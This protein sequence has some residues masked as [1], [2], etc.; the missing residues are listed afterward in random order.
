MINPKRKLTRAVAFAILF[1]FT[2]LTGAQ[3]L[4]AI[5][6]N[7]QLPVLD[8]S[9]DPIG[10]VT[11]P[12]LNAI[13]DNIMNI[14][15]TDE[16]SIIKWK[17]FSIG[18]DAIVNFTRENGGTFN[19]LNFVNSGAV[20]EIY[21]QLTALG[22][23]IFIANPAGVTIGNSA[24]I[25]VGS[26]YVTNKD[27]GN[28]VDSLKGLKDAK[29]IRET[30][31]GLSAGTNAQLMSLG[32]I[33]NATNVTFD[34]A[35]IV[36]DTDR[37]YTANGDTGELKQVNGDWFAG[38]QAGG[39]LLKTTG[40][41]IIT[42]D[43]DNVILGY[44]KDNSRGVDF[45]NF[46]I[47]VVAN[48]GNVTDGELNYG[49]TWIHDLAE[50]H[51]MND[52]PSG[53]YA[54]RNSID[55]Y[56]TASID[57]GKGF[58]PIG[59]SSQAFTGRFDGLG[60]S[61]FGLNVKEDT[62]AAGL[63]GVT[64][65]AHLK[66]FT[67]NG[68]SISGGEYV[69]AAVGSASGG[70]IENITNTA[71]VSGK[72]AEYNENGYISDGGVGGI[73]GY[74]GGTTMSGLINIGT[75][76]GTDDSINV[77]GIVGNM[78][79]STLTGETYNLGSVTGGWNIGGIA[80]QMTNSA[81]IG[82]VG[83]DA[84]QIYNQ[85]NVEGKYNVGGIAGTLSGGTI[86]NAANYGNVTAEGHTKDTYEYHTAAAQDNLD[87]ATL[88]GNLA[89]IA[90]K[91]A[92]A[93][94]IA[95]KTENSAKISNVVNEGDV[96]TKTEGDDSHYIAGN[97]GGIVGRAEDT[98]I[99]NAENKENT[100]AGAHNVGGVAGFLG[101]NS[102]VDVGVN[103]GGD[104]TATGARRGNSYVKERIR[105]YSP[106][107]N[108]AFNVGN[109]GGI[110]GYLF[111]DKAKVKNSGN[112]GT[113][114]SANIE[115]V[116]IVPET[117]KAA[118]V[119]GVV[120]KI[121]M[122]TSTT[123]ETVKD[124][125]KDNYKNGVPT[126][127]NSYSTGN[128]RGYTGVGG[129][130]GMMYNGSVAGSYNLGT[131]QSSR[132][133]S[134]GREPLNMGGVVGDTT[135]DT[136]ANAVIYDVYN[137]G[138]IGDDDYEYYGR[139][140]GGVVGRLSGELEKAYNTGD[141][142]NGY[143]TVGGI[144][145]WWAAGD[146][147]N[148]FN[149]GNITVVNNDDENGVSQVGGIAGAHSGAGST[150]SYAYNLGTIRSFTP[151]GF[152]TTGDKGRLSNAVG[153][154]IGYARN[155]QGTGL[156]IKNVYTT[157]NI[158]AA[159][160]N[161]NDT[162][163]IFDS[164]DEG[165]GAI[166][167]REDYE[168]NNGTSSNPEVNTAYY[169][170]MY[171][172]GF[173]TLSNMEGVDATIIKDA[174]G[175]FNGFVDF[176]F[177]YQI[178]N[179]VD[180]SVD[181]W[182]IYDGTTPILNAFLPNSESYFSRDDV[183]LG[184]LNIDS[185]QYGT[186]ANPLL[187]IIN[188]KGDGSE[189]V[190]LDW[191]TLGSSGN[192]SFAVYNGGLT[193]N[194]FGTETGYYRGTIYADG[195]LNVK[196]TADHNFNLGS[197]ANLYGTNVTLNANG[198][199]TIYGNVT[200]TNGDISIS[201]GDIEILG[202][203]ASSKA[204][205]TT[206]PVKNIAKEM[207]VA[208]NAFSNLKDPKAAVDTVS[209]AYAHTPNVGN[210]KDGNITVNASG[211]AEVLYG[212]LGTGSVSTAG[213]FTVNGGTTDGGSVYVD[214]DLSGTT[215]N[216]NLSAG[217]EVLLDIT[218]I[219]KAHSNGEGNNGKDS[220]HEFLA[221]YKEDGGNKITLDSANDDEIIAIDM[222]D[223][224]KFDLDKY[225][226]GNKTFV[227]A[228]QALGE[229]LAGKTHIWISNANQ[230]KGIQSYYD[231]VTATGETTKILNYNFA[232]KG[233][234]DA[235]ALTGYEEIGGGT[236]DG[237]SGTFDGRDFRI[238][239]L[240]TNAADANNASSGIFGK[241]AGTVKDLRVYASKFFGGNGE[242]AGTIAS[243]VITQTKEDG[244]TVSGT[245]TGVTTFGNTVT[246]E[247]GAAGGIVGKN[248]GSILESTASDS[249]TVSGTDAYAGGVAGVN[250]G[251]IGEEGAEGESAQ[252]TANSAVRSGAD[253]AASIGGVVGKNEIGGKV[254]L[255]NSLGVTTGA[256][257]KATGGIAGTNNGTMTS[258]YNESIVMGKYNVGGV[259]GTNEGNMSNAVNATSVTADTT[260]DEDDNTAGNVGGLAGVNSGTIDSGR[261][262]G[263]VTGGQNVGGLVG[264]N[265]KENEKKPGILKNL[266]N[267]LAAVINGK[268]FV[269]GIAGSNSGAITG[270]SNLVNEG[271]ISG[272]TYVGG[273][274]GANSGT[275]NGN[276][277]G[278][279]NGVGLTNK[280]TV[281]GNQFVGGVAG[282]NAQGGRITNTNSDAD[283]EATGDNAKYFGGVAGQNDGT[284][285]GATNSGELIIGTKNEDNEIVG[286][287]DYVGGIVGHNT[288]DL[289]GILR[290]EGTVLGKDKVGGLAGANENTSLLISEEGRLI[291]TNE[292]DVTATGGT[293]G[294]IFYENNGAI[295]NADLTNTGTVK[296]N[297]GGDSD[298][299]GNGGLF[300]VNHGDI[301]Y[302]TLTNKGTVTG[303]ENGQRGT[304]GVIGINHGAI[305]NSELRNDKEVAG[306]SNVGGLIGIN[307]GEVKESSLING[308]DGVVTGSGENVGGLIGKNTGTITGGRN[309]AG[310]K[311]EHKIYN[312]G[313]VTGDSNVGGLIGYNAVEDGKSGYLYAG[314]NTGEVS[315]TTNI[316][317]IVGK[318]E[319]EVSS[320]FN[321]I[322]TAIENEETKY[323][324]VTG[325]TNVGG[326]VGSNIG[327]LINA[328]NT[329]TVTGGNG[330]TGNI[331]GVNTGNGIVEYVYAI[332]D[333][334]DTNNLVGDGSASH[335][336]IFTEGDNKANHAETYG[337]FGETIKTNAESDSIWRIYDGYSTPLLR[338][339][340]TDAK[341][342]GSTNQFTYN[343]NMQGI[344][345]LQNVTA[346]DGLNGSQISSIAEVLLTALE[347]K[348]A[349]E[350]YLAFSSTQI[351]ANNSE[352]G[353]NPNNLGYDIDATFSIGKLLL[354]SVKDIIASIIY[355]GSKYEVTGGVLEGVIEGDS[356]D[357][358]V[359][360]A[361]M[362]K[363][364]LDK[365][366]VEGSE[367]DKS[368]GGR[369]TADVL[370]GD[371]GK[372]AAYENS[373]LYNGSLSLTGNDAD[374]Y[375]LAE[376]TT[377][378]GSITVEKATLNVELGTVERTY[379]N[380]D[381]TTEGGY[382]VTDSFKQ[383]L[384]NGDENLGY[385]VSDFNVTVAE[386]G[387]TALTGD[388]TGRV[389]KDA[390]LENESYYWTAEKVSGVD[391][392][393]L[394][395]LSKNY[396]IVV[397]GQGKSIVNKAPLSITLNDVTRIYGDA[398]TFV[399][400]IGY[401]I[402]SVDGLV[403]GDEKK[404]LTLSETYKPG[405]GD[406]TEFGD[407][408]L[409]YFNGDIDNVRT[410]NVLPGDKTYNWTIA[411]ADYGKA[412]TG[413]DKLT[414]NYTVNVT[415]GKS[416]VTPKELSI[417]SIL[418]TIVYGDQ[419][420]TG[421]KIAEG[422]K[423]TGIVYDDDVSLSK[424]LKIEDAEFAAGGSY[425][426][427][428]NGRTTADA[429]IYDNETLTFSDLTLSGTKAGNY[430]LNKDVE[431]DIVVK[432]AVLTLTPND[433]TTT[434]GTAFDENS[435]SYT[436]SG[437]TN[438]DEESALRTAI[439]VLEYGNYAAFD[440]EG[441]KY[442][443]DAATHKNVVYIKNLNEKTL[444]NY[445]VEQGNRG[446]A[447][448]TKATLNVALN[449]VE[450]TYGDT[451][452]T[453]GDYSINTDWLD[454][455]INGDG[456]IYT[457][458]EISISGI[459]SDKAV[460][461]EYTTNDAG[462]HSW[463]AKV[464]A[465]ALA[466]NYNINE[467]AIGS[468]IVN[469]A[470][471]TVNAGHAETTYGTPFDK[472]KYY[473]DLVGVT[474]GDS[475][476]EIKA[477]IGNV[478]YDNTTAIEDGG[479]RVTDNAGV[480]GVLSILTD[481]FGIELGNY[482]IEKVN[483][484]TA[485]VE[486]ADLFI[487]AHDKHTHVGREPEYT[488]TTLD[489]LELVNGD[490]LAD[491]SHTFGIEEASMLDEAGYYAG[492]I[493]AVV[494]GQYYYDGAHDWSEHHGVFA[495]YNVNVEAGNLTV[496]RLMP[497]IQ[498]YNYGWLYDD[499]PYGRKWNFRERKAEV[500]FH[501]GGMEYDE[502]M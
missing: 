281:S 306:G 243:E 187:T 142:Y 51:A 301:T 52:D 443:D 399:G 247:N 402:D 344:K 485:T 280:A 27:I 216:I 495:N 500:F 221:N 433:A 350:N 190:T 211:A 358:D 455:L 41:N 34:G 316:G 143:G 133:V 248:S 436:L 354:L 189:T 94:G 208:G 409:Y 372:V 67:L 78:S 494:D 467:I 396:D 260:V 411:G 165:V 474:N 480:N 473:Y 347:Q 269:G 82:N 178:G 259:A 161:K 353:F 126:V 120:G 107:E 2:S 154:I 108:E 393:T 428:R 223:D 186:A 169:V 476:S 326:I 4:Y 463:S 91:A 290:N 240:N 496:V 75:I 457:G 153:G 39:D 282:H 196:G 20:S 128:V 454:K 462:E 413:V 35:R 46:G 206:Q 159:I 434:Y 37:I 400:G 343:A 435:Y 370:Y 25:N 117:A 54:L 490:T 32:A 395:N 414:N 181:G 266:S 285:D 177:N 76:T 486:K 424:E 98:T 336:Y 267:A 139:H 333:A 11:I 279:D 284:I 446:A 330:T 323:G 222:W 214:S 9:F 432:K 24:Q 450:R 218:N 215:G 198:D 458:D 448:I 417:S 335:S 374:N 86:T 431:G 397:N 315:G 465:S 224:G 340:L 88:K 426:S 394:T 250:T 492:K 270:A 95:G 174:N 68:G 371:D 171:E 1:C 152:K 303:D 118:N 38:E 121:D 415:P 26:L 302:S 422:G 21:G 127:L 469:K 194:N 66:N 311:Y 12:E 13:K 220:L 254:W 3:P 356:V 430:T 111:G 227:G 197:S 423:L 89:S 355:G 416:K 33:T 321:T 299:G 58:D 380:T 493:A 43:K 73:V 200:S 366:I 213:N 241:L 252:I 293:A 439:G 180:N 481:L 45:D 346:A 292:G 210:V 390:N 31:A 361:D 277:G 203:L 179:D 363:E 410:N 324:A 342:E 438:D 296:G 148:V 238:I 123:L 129:V 307:D 81:Q 115:D 65:G 50:L 59:D 452:L 305:T 246:V 164:T 257:S 64:N 56:D 191:K 157:N 85:L 155:Y 376:D 398:E 17:D 251:S 405:V 309:D 464:N 160:D 173:E 74:A 80:G 103:N 163:I 447:I 92:N 375:A 351:A 258:L 421:F 313:T 298:D 93:G 192:A 304:G 407:G 445:N 231:R 262:A 470:K 365:L 44:T 325:K 199:A 135:E 364:E 291:V 229:D 449:P 300:G 83:D 327:K 167:G 132:A 412:F 61:I 149:T 225:N 479:D 209:D 460:I 182:R 349:G 244:S 317:G 239:G 69:G 491:F 226:D 242:N 483:D 272:E 134:G 360:F 373:L 49:Y 271:K 419:N 140:V 110:V 362:S 275:I 138:T 278:T 337:D 418:A 348:N 170:K 310:T 141:I 471:L 109:I 195:A 102:T 318:N 125:A 193:L 16:T 456:L 104:I 100:V 401:G 249:V 453:H 42:T 230:L 263:V 8:N 442:T 202:K 427:S 234:I 441:G 7:T 116:N 328:Y 137:A 87:G 5:P 29:E 501:E 381:I 62:D 451:T 338:V 499:A 6:P 369:A 404:Q 440:G 389:T 175:N 72:G 99:T 130:I 383:H 122:E 212:N 172:S 274:V 489:E 255:A 420:G 188:A 297:V 377:V 403:N 156:K 146:I 339:F 502:D 236:T 90:V 379:G 332:K 408:A 294:G 48:N 201:G 322:M 437:V 388:S 475:E 145:G 276:E 14:T 283:L 288:G 97:V 53:W 77:G 19:S 341:Y 233:N 368:K 168:G 392:E 219:A 150:L 488:G 162:Q 264:A 70:V 235:S 22:G 429:G 205:K 183:D 406:G 497:T 312:N 386:N 320:V 47:K 147:K 15:Q 144:V 96:T 498:H 352:E 382:K 232:L 151:Y 79:D 331:A 378:G 295:K 158:Y 112:R 131:V 487:T 237:F 40:L 461:D 287:A 261:N 106:E 387:D 482:E 289:N 185:V 184:S 345:D 319:G 124:D 314:Y 30:I 217:G 119:G 36:L 459:I 385:A 101:E 105:P 60:Y 28:A 357:I 256:E 136:K 472:N 57:D 265:K 71:S 391:G 329:T 114:H 478:A 334:D 308:V 176:K 468:S 18:A 63:F 228:I 477:Q 204:G 444:T 384:V 166:Y 55:A 466:Q 286:T 84:F 425:E 207:T 359:D 484:G 268:K 253:E 10:G 23:N 367:Y 113:V 273:I 245:I